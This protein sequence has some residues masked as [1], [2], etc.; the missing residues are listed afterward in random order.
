MKLSIGKRGHDENT[1]ELKSLFRLIGKNEDA[2]TYSLGY[3]ISRNT[4]FLVEFLKICGVF[5]RTRG[6]RYNKK[7]EEGEIHLQELRD[8]SKGGRKDI[9][10]EKSDFLRVVIEAKVDGSIPSS[11]QL[12]KYTLTK[13][14]KGVIDLKFL[15]KEWG[16]FKNRHLVTL[17]RAEVSANEYSGLKKELLHSGMDIHIHSIQWG[18]VLNLVDRWTNQKNATNG[19]AHLWHELLKEFRLF[20]KEDYDMKYFAHEVIFVQVLKNLIYPICNEDPVGYYFDGGRKDFTYPPCLFFVPCYGQKYKASKTAELIRRIDN[21]EKSSGPEILK[22]PSTHPM[23]KAFEKHT[24][25]FSKDVRN[26]HIHV[27]TLGAKIPIPKVKQK[28]SG[29]NRG[30]KNIVDFLSE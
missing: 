7:V 16:A 15:Q 27:F 22:K 6:V 3:L 2:L 14:S 9:T 5:P 10:I 30:Y 4:S 11:Q 26:E 24:A 25:K 12:A 13:D 20:L 8:K 21:Y 18:D 28:F 29:P 1:L 19:Q 17:T 23:R